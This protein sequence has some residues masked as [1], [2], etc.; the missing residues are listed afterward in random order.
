MQALLVTTALVLIGVFVWRVLGRRA[1]RLRHGAGAQAQDTQHVRRF[2][3]PGPAR[4]ISRAAAAARTPGGV[5]RVEGVDWTS[6]VLDELPYPLAGLT[7]TAPQGLYEL[8]CGRHRL[9]VG[10]GAGR[11]V[12]D[13]I[14]EP[15]ARLCVRGTGDELTV[16]V[17][18]APEA[19]DAAYIHYPTWAR[20]PL[21]GPRAARPRVDLPALLEELELALASRGREAASRLGER[22]VGVPLTRDELRALE[23][24]C[25]ERVAAAGAPSETSARVALVLPRPLSDGAHPSR[26][27]QTA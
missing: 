2:G 19:I 8:T 4:P 3:T 17:L 5:L 1:A 11:R 14:V 7:A 23:R 21:L 20:G 6:C 16:A 24:A 27:R 26:D 25:G 15:G 12:V 9:A 22:L 10:A 13:F 18:D